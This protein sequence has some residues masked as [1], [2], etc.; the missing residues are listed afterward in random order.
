[1]TPLAPRFKKWVKMA[2]LK[3]VII[4]LSICCVP[5][6]VLGIVVSC[7]VS[8]SQQG[9]KVGTDLTHQLKDKEAEMK[10]SSQS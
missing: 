9:Y 7:L 3:T 8:C 4:L 5:G 10:R 6:P 1:M 2:L